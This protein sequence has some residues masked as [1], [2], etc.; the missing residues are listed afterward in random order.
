MGCREYGAWDAVDKLCFQGKQGQLPVFWGW[1][2]DKKRIVTIY[3]WS[4]WV[5]VSLP[6]IFQQVG[7]M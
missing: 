4:S 2:F 5:E 1:E 6:K 3:V 7:C